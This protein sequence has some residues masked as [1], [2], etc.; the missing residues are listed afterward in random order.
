MVSTIGIVRIDADTGKELTYYTSR[1]AVTLDGYDAAHVRKVIRG[2]RETHEG[3]GW[4]ILS[5][6]A[7][8]KLVEKFGTNAS[9]PATRASKIVR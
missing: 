3:F 2:E 5:T 1:S 8:R 6:K 7:T 9:I 4:K